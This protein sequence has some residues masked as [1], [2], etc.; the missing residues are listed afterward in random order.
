[1]RD[2]D[3]ITIDAD[4]LTISVA[5]SDAVMEERRAAWVAPPFK[6]TRG[7]MYRCTPRQG[8]ARWRHLGSGP[9][10]RRTA[11][12]RGLVLGCIEANICK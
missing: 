10:R 2:G 7:T 12:F 3:E 4:T 8:F 11:N 1:M 5:I 6:Y 9:H